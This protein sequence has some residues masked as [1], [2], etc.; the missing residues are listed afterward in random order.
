VADELRRLPGVDV[1]L[2]DG[3]KGELTV[4]VDGRTVA[5]K[6]G[7]APPTPQEVV[8]AVRSAA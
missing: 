5:E 3:N 2:E 1:R 4:L 8:A 7:E 6:K